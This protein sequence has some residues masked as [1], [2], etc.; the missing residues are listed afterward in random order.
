MSA[1]PSDSETRGGDESAESLVARC[2]PDLR[3]FVRRYFGGPASTRESADDIVQSVCREVLEHADVFERDGELGMQRWMQRVARRKIVDRHRHATADRRDAA[4]ETPGVDS[5][6]LSRGA[7]PS[8]T[9]A[10]REELN[11][12]LAAFD[13]L[14]EVVRDAILLSRLEGLSYDDIGKRLG[15]TPGAVRNL[16][17][18]GLAKLAD[19]LDD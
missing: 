6:L 18:R 16:V 4:R 7:T 13:G 5:A 1:S 11:A 12:T 8:H 9:V 3:R 2:A 17:Y 14:P 19:K 15:R 10:I